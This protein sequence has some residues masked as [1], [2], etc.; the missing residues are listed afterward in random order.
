MTASVVLVEASPRRASDGVAQP[1]RLAGG[2]AHLPYRYGGQGWRAGIASLPAIVTSLDYAGDELGTGGVP[3]ALT[4][5]WSPSTRADLNAMAA[6]FWD[7]APMTVRLG[8]EGTALPP[9]L[10]TGTAL[11]SSA[12]AGLFQ[13]A[14]ADPAADLKRPLLVDRFA[15]TGSIEGPAEWKGRIRRRA[16]GRCFNVPGEPIDKARNIYCF[17]DPQRRW[18]AFDDV[19]ERGAP[20]DPVTLTFL[21]WQGSAEATYAAL[22]IAVPVSGGGVLC[23][24]IAC[25]KWWNAPVAL[26][27]DVRGE[28]EGGYAESAPE[29]TQRLVAARSGLSFVAG[30]VAAAKAARPALCGWFEGDANRT[31][32]QV[33]DELLRDVSLL[34][35]LDGGLISLRPWEW[36]ASVATARSHSAKRVRTHKPVKARN[37]GYRRNESPM[38]RGDLAA[39]VLASEIAFTNGDLL[40]DLKPAE[41]GADKTSNNVAADTA[42]VGGKLSGVVLD[43][44]NLTGELGLD[45]ENFVKRMEGVDPVTG[46]QRA[47]IMVDYMGIARASQAIVAGPEGSVIGWAANEFYWYDTGVPGSVPRQAGKIVDGRWTLWDVYIDKLEVGSVI[48]QSINPGAVTA[49]TTFTGPDVTITSASET[50]IIETGFF[51]VGDL[52][53]GKAIAGVHF[54]QD[55][56]LNFDTAMRIRSYI[57]TGAGYTPLDDFVSGQDVDSGNVRFSWNVGFSIELSSSTPTRIKITGQASLL[58]SG[59]GTLS[60]SAARTPVI[61]L[62]KGQR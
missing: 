12:E 23:P 13:I 4:I 24:S 50:A 55:G 59:H 46:F 6:L 40:S 38:A 20:T 54:L 8:G 57:D 26:H 62:M 15:G 27:A 17:G 7:D 60:S 5:V 35:V 29:I 45:N 56:T 25:V 2:G 48:R 10:L 44:L 41:A 21:G 37:L 42:K 3:Q 16:W 14:M 61:S 49:S 51:E 22:E 33:L 47:T 19:R 18:Q 31:V 43:E 53:Y 34:W 11:S 1:V 30:N 58:P 36:G 9:V 52:L 28:I 32:A 39:I